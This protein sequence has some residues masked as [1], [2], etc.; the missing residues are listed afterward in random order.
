MRSV[1]KTSS[2]EDQAQSQD[3]DDDTADGADAIAA[4]RYAVMSWLSRKPA[5][6]SKPDPPQDTR[7][8][9]YGFERMVA[10]NEQRKER[11]VRA[12]RKAITN[13]GG[14]ETHAEPWS[15]TE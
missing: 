12:L 15:V 14:D 5:E 13:R 2:R 8:R 7:D 6:Y 1:W 9:E 3:P 4:L 11:E 10:A